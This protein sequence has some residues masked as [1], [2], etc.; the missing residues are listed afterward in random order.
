MLRASDADRDRV[1]DVLRSA[2]AD[3]RLTLAELEERLDALYAAKTYAELEPV[4]DDL[5]GTLDVLRVTPSTGL[6]RTEAAGEIARV[7]GQ[8]T[9]RE[10]QAIFGGVVRRGQWVVP[11]HYRVKAVFGGADLDLRRAQLETHEI[12]IEARA[13]FGGV[14]IIVPPD[15]T[16]VIDG[17]GVF[18]GFAGNAE[19]VQPPPGAPAVRVTGK[20][21]FGGVNVERKPLDR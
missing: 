7:G 14:N 9:S 15:V 16:V 12:T 18:G 3:G 1:A 19:D 11:R 8:P 13:V 20:A 2:A 6:Q 10:V 21:V 5:P 17:S 4:M